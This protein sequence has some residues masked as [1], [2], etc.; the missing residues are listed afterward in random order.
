MKRFCKINILCK[1]HAEGYIRLKYGK[2]K[3]W[4]HI[5]WYK[6]EKKIDV[7]HPEMGYIILMLK[8]TEHCPFKIWDIF[9]DYGNFSSLIPINNVS[10]SFNNLTEEHEYIYENGILKD[11][12]CFCP[13][14]LKYHSIKLL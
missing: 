2:K 4:C 1:K 9:K 11:L 12:G 14:N 3:L 6:D 13:G 10:T 7:I 8:Y 5:Y